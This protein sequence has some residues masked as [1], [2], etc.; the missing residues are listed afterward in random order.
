MF[1][2]TKD[3]IGRYHISIGVGRIYS[4]RDL[5]EVK[6][7]LDHFWGE[8]SCLLGSNPNCP[9]CRAINEEMARKKYLEIYT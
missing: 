4:T 9:L 6:T 1:K 8:K 2:V 3:A 7:A 5:E